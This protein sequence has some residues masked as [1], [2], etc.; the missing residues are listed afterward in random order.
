MIPSLSAVLPEDLVMADPSSLEVPGAGVPR[1]LR[2][3]RLTGVFTREYFLEMLRLQWALG[4]REVRA[5]TLLMFD[6]KS[7]GQYSHTFGRNGGDAAIKRVGRLLA[8]SFRRGADVVGRWE[9]GT[10]CVLA[11]STEMGPTVSYAHTVAQRVL[12][13]QI[14]FPRSSRGRF[15]T[16]SV[17]AARL[18]PGTGVT[19]DTLVA[20]A[21]RALDASRAEPESRVMI[22]STGDNTTPEVRID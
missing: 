17:G 9:G 14:H 11:Y 8:A 16:V 2:E 7:L 19:A 13:Q 20:L 22:A 5:L 3:D 6:I 10:F 18:M 15:L 1:W 21:Q 4:Q 12:E